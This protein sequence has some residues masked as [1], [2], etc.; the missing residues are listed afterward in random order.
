MKH[1][2][3]NLAF[4]NDLLKLMRTNVNVNPIAFVSFLQEKKSQN[5]KVKVLNLFFSQEVTQPSA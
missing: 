4:S 3:Y 2:L 5:P 1:R